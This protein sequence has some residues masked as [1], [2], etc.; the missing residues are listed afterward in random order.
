MTRDAKQDLY[1]VFEGITEEKFLKR[2]HSSFD[3]TYNVILKNAHGKDNI[4][5]EY[6]KIKRKNNYSEVW[7]MYDLDNSINVDSILSLYDDSDL[8]LCKEDVYFI[9]PEIE[10]L[11]IMCKTEQA[12][13]TDYVHLIDK[14]FKVKEYDKR[15]AQLDKIMSLIEDTNINDLFDRMK[16]LLSKDDKEI[17]STNYDEMLNKIFVLK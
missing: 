6:K 9:N 15:E 8:D 14:W 2:I 13:I 7:V 3:S 5:K 1:I 11:F 10:M 17:R 4:V 12:P 16:R